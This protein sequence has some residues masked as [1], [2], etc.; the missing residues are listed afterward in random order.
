MVIRIPPGSRADKSNEIHVVSKK[1]TKNVIEIVVESIS[2]SERRCPDVSAKLM[3]VL[4][5]SACRC[6]RTKRFVMSF[7]HLC[8]GFPRLLFPATIPC[9]IV[10][11]KPLCRVTWPKYLSF[12]VL[13]NCTASSLVD[14]VYLILGLMPTPSPRPESARPDNL[15]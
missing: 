11:S 9:I 7:S 13:Q 5:H 8:L 4:R 15:I 2:S 3:P 12:D 6:H 1:S 10:F 14:E